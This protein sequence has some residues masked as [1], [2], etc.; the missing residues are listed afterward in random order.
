MTQSMA[1]LAEFQEFALMDTICRVAS[2]LLALGLLR[3]FR[4]SLD[5]PA[6][7]AGVQRRGPG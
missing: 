1:S 5:L 2:D 4:W 7:Q 6:L 3:Q